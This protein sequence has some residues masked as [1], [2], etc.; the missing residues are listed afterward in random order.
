MA[1]TGA[2]TMVEEATQLTEKQVAHANKQA[3]E[4]RQRAEKQ[5][6]KLARQQ[7]QETASQENRQAK[8]K[9]KA[10]NMAKAEEASEAK[11]KRTE[12]RKAKAVVDNAARDEERKI[13]AER[14]IAVVLDLGAILAH[15]QAAA[16]PD[17]K[18][19]L[20]GVVP[21]VAVTFPSAEAAQA[22]IYANAAEAQVGVRV[23]VRPVP[24]PARMIH[25]PKDGLGTRAEAVAALASVLTAKCL[26]PAFVEGYGPRIGV[27]FS[28]EA[29][30]KEACGRFQREG[31]NVLGVELGAAGVMG[32]P[33]SRAPRGTPRGKKGPGGRTEEGQKMEE[34]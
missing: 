21:Q 29:E 32:V 23:S 11:R 3:E 13:K 7:A 25:F 9:R 8:L 28:S 26:S 6:G 4:Q 16:G 24:H 1:D 18:V 20:K 22:Y 33:P 5:A 27:Q 30:A 31:L 12:E 2:T 10:D 14:N 19:M 34:A 15:V 17:A